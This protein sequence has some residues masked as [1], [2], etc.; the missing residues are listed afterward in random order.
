MDKTIKL[1]ICGLG[2]FARSRLLPALSNIDEIKLECVV[3]GT[4]T[5]AS[6]FNSLTEL[7]KARSCDLLHITSPNALHY[8]HTLECL[9]ASSHVICEKPLSLS[10][11]QARQLLQKAQ[12]KNCHL[13]VGQMLRSS[14]LVQ[15][16]GNMIDSGT[17]GAIESININLCYSI[18]ISKRK[19]LWDHK[20]SGGGCVIDAG[21]HCFDLLL[22]LFKQDIVL[23]NCSLRKNAFN[24]ETSGLIDGVIG[25]VSCIINLNANAEYES[26][27][28]IKGDRKN[29]VINNFAATWGTSRVSIIEPK[30]N[31]IV[32]INEIDVSSVYEKQYRRIIDPILN[33]KFDYSM[34]QDAIKNLM[35]IEEIYASA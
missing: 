27:I 9:E 4:Q 34:A 10:S 12:E 7:L 8:E 26:S 6:S 33:N 2:R 25:D 14:P 35:L 20:V 23:R 24:I 21:I 29:A 18:D 28:F 16:I 15:K 32:S 19:W 5:G 13:Y 1:G 11:A 31:E 17:F 30:T 3:R 22:Y